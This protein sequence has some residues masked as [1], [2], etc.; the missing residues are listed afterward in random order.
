[1][2][3]NDLKINNKNSADIGFEKQIWNAARILRGNMDSAEY[4]QVVL[5][6]IFLKYI[7]DEFERKYMNLVEEGAGFEEDIDEYISEGIFFVPPQARWK[8]IAEKAHTPEIGTIIDEAM[9]AIEKENKRLKDILPKNFA[10]PELDKRRLGDVVDLFTNIRMIEH[11]NEKDILGRTYEYCL[12]KFAEQEGKLAGE[13]YTP[14]CVVKTLVEVLKPFNGRV[15]DPCCGS[16]GMFVQSANFI[17][18]HSGNINNIS[19]YGQDSNPTTWKLANM[20]LAIQGIEADLGGFNGDTFT[21]DRHPF[22]KADYILANPPFNLSNWGEARLKDDPRWKYGVPPANNANF[23]WLQHMIYHLSPNGKI[24]MVLANTAL[25]VSS[26][27]EYEIRKNIIEDDLV[28]CIVSLPAHLFYTTKIKVSI[29][30]LNKNKKQKGKILF[31]DSR[32]LGHMASRTLKEFSQSEIEK[33]A[34]TVSKFQNNEGYENISGFCQVADLEEIQKKNYNISPSKYVSGV[35]DV[36]DIG[37]ITDTFEADINNLTMLKNNT[38]NSFENISSI[39]NTVSLGGPKKD[40]DLFSNLNARDLTS[41]EGNN[42]IQLLK[43]VERHSSYTEKIE[44][45]VNDI[46]ERLFKYWFIDFNFPNESGYPYQESGGKLHKTAYGDIPITWQCITMGSFLTPKNIKVGEREGISEYS[47]TNSGVHPRAQKFNKK[48]SSNFKKN[49]IVEKG[50]IV[51]GM[52]REI[53]NFGI[54]KDE[55]GSVSPAYHVYEIDTDVINAEF[56]E[57]Y[58]RLCSDYFLSLI[59]PGA[60]EGQVLDKE[61]L[62]H[63]LIVCPPLDIQSKYMLIRKLFPLQLFRGL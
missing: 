39:L 17:E 48:L 12:A 1:M 24:G 25:S 5:G 57:V 29:W 16:G 49:K 4:K 9:R 34:N 55:I 3:K 43:E 58:M 6:L 54:M 35:I 62:Q 44:V 14:S 23:A 13:F 2:E 31:I 8:L 60:R 41:L 59:K 15:Y 19:V 46:S 33:I 11:G 36:A 40:Y 21:N 20:N 50:D 27:S 47:T 30:F 52:S 45:L 32:N 10:R 22:L 28:E 37:E 42:A 18:N 7:S 26:G 56:L 63:K 51:F 53:F 38:K 61:E